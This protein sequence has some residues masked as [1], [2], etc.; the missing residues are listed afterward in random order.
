MRRLPIYLVLDVSESMAG[1]NLA[2]L[3]EG[4]QR[5]MGTLRTDPQ[6]LETAWVSIVAFAGVVRELL[7]L[8]ELVSVA[9]PRL[10]VGGG[11][12]LGGAMMFVMDQVDSQ[13]RRNT[14]EEKGDWKPIVFLITDGKP[15]DDVLPMLS[16]WSRYADRVTLVAISIG[17]AA[18]LRVLSQLTSADKVLRLEDT[19]SGGFGEF[20]QWV[21]RT[22]QAR[23]RS[24]GDA[25]KEEILPE[26]DTAIMR[27]LSRDQSMEMVDETSIHIV[28]KCGKTKLPY[29]LRYEPAGAAKDAGPRY[30]LSG[31]YPISA[32][33]FEMSSRQPSVA[34]VSPA[35][36]DTMP[37]CPHC[38]HSSLA[39]CDCGYIFCCGDDGDYTCPWCER[40]ARFETKEKLPDVIRARG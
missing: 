26:A 3:E 12:S 9:V 5:I 1:E 23:S 10:P 14:G 33:Y 29:I 17:R 20:V 2:H 21:S 28:P 16:R 31:C 36:L 15:T 6:A 19:S 7:P 34:R 18:D 24:V 11:T 32:V 30:K 22:V 4:L 40:T 8:T 38:A 27:K 37:D 35:M 13:V 25:V 39:F